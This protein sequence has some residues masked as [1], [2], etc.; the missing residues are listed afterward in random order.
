MALR[1]AG[2]IGSRWSVS[3]PSAVGQGSPQR[4]RNEWIREHRGGHRPKVELPVTLPVRG[5][6]RDVDLMPRRGSRR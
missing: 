2:S 5:T 6:G 3:R 1:G 4:A